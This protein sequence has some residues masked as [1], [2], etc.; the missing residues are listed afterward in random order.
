MSSSNVPATQ[1]QKF[2]VAISTEGYRNLINNTLGDPERARRFV[3]AITSAVAVNPQLQDCTPGTI[4]AGALRSMKLR[5]S[6]AFAG[7]SEEQLQSIDARLHTIKN[8]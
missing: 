5:E 3:A 7:F 1:K 2:S 8:Q 6:L 4:L